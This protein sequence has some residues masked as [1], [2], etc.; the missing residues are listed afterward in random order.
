MQG[1]LAHSIPSATTEATPREFASSVALQLHAA[2][3]R[4]LDG[5]DVEKNFFCNVTSLLLYTGNTRGTGLLNDD[6]LGSRPGS[7]LYEHE[8]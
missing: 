4:L 3:L 7:E 1:A 5:F 8:H 6:I 2:C